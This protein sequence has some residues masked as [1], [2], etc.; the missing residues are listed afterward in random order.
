MSELEDKLNNILSSPKEMEKIM[1]MAK[2]LSGSLS[3]GGAEG[4][5]NTPSAAANASPP[6][7]VDPKLLKIMTKLM[8]EYNSKSD[9]KTALMEAVKPFLKEERRQAVDRAE[10]ITRLARVARLAM[11]EFSGD[12]R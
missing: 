4:S 9:D 11:D 12:D 5:K 10:Q 3:I 6:P 8:G 7:A 1:D 2:S